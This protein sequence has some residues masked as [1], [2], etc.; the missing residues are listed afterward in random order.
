MAQSYTVKVRKK[1]DTDSFGSDEPV[2]KTVLR[3]ES[4]P[5]AVVFDY[6]TYGTG[7]KVKRL[8]VKHSELAR[9]VV[10]AEIL[11][12]PLAKKNALKRRP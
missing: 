2:K 7:E 12:P 1:G 3:S 5:E 8:T 6:N 11:G 9:A 4:P 10:M